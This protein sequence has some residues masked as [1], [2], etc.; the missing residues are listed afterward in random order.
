MMNTGEIWEQPVELD[1]VWYNI[2]ATIYGKR[3][4]YIPEEKLKGEVL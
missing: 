2:V 3:N 1:M 4:F